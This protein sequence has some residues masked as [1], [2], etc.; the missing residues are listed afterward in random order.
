MNSITKVVTVRYGHNDEPEPL[1]Q[2]P[3]VVDPKVLKVLQ[4]LS[5]TPNR[6]ERIV[7]AAACAVELVSRFERDSR[8]VDFTS[9]LA[10]PIGDIPIA[11]RVQLV[12][13]RIGNVA[14]IDFTAAGH[15]H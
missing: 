13:G 7:S 2:C 1:F 11:M 9:T 14:R 4:M 15:R 12:A 8:Y 10:L 5:G 3:V 6:V